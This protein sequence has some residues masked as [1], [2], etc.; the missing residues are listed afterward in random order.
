MQDE[1][2]ATLYIPDNLYI[3][4]TMNDIDRSVESFD[5]AMRRRFVW[6]EIS[7]EESQVMFDSSDKSII[8]DKKT[9]I[10][11]RMNSLNN[12]IEN[13][14]GLNSHYKIGAAYYLKLQDHKGDFNKLWLYHIEPLLKEYLRGLP[15]YKNALLKLENAYNLK[16]E[17][18][19]NN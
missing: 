9:E 7:A 5:F 18:D 4:G 3:I 2:Q 1:E 6:K 11:Q 8:K 16:T 13:I 10:I 14:D 12:V 19:E 15:D 17:S